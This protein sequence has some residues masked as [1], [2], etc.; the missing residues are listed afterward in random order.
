MAIMPAS[1]LPPQAVIVLLIAACALVGVE[2]GDRPFMVEI[3]SQ[4]RA[5]FHVAQEVGA[6]HHPMTNLVLDPEVHLDCAR[7]DVVGSKQS[8]LVS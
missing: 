2:V 3:H 5:G 1:V 4:R 6:E 7:A 8:L